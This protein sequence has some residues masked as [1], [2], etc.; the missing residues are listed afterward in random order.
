VRKRVAANTEPFIQ[1]DMEFATERDASV[2]DPPVTVFMGDGDAVHQPRTFRLCP[3]GMQFYSRTPMDE[4]CLLEFKLD[5]PRPHRKPETISCCGIVVNCRCEKEPSLFRVW[6]KF[7]DLPPPAQ[8][9]LSCLA[10]SSEYLCPFCE[11]F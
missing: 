11:N 5:L 2:K 8:H 1:R 4:C 7:L 6:I 10:K 9:R 3:L